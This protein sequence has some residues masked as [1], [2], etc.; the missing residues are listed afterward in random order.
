ML[1]KG[2]SMRLVIAGGNG[3]IGRHFVRHA[4]DA[5]HA[6]TLVVRS[7][8]EACPEGVDL[9][10]GGI[11]ALCERPDVLEAADAVCHLASASIPATSQRDPLAD[12]T[13]N[14]LPAIRL[15]EAMRAHGN[16][17]ILFLSSGGAIYG[18][19]Q[20]TPIRENHPT[21]PISPYGVGKLAIEKYLEC[22][23][24]LHGFSTVAIRPANPYGPDQGKVGELGVVWTFIR[25]IQQDAVA[26]LYGDGSTVR[27]H[28]HVDDLCRLMLAC[29][30]QRAEGT[31]N[32]G[33]G[34]GTSLKEL[35]TM[36]ERIVG[37]PL[38]IDR[39]PARAFD[40]PA[41]VL[42]ITRARKELGWEPQISLEQG[43]ARMT[44]AASA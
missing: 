8:P 29:L 41:I 16:R 17:R 24:A 1:T 11:D 42:D 20:T 33:G 38:Q 35:I 22:Y 19:P 34:Q 40:P 6:V 36:I 31:F 15:L 13:G 26:T 12:A 4:R 7:A 23:A 32:C 28:V 43:I 39:K 5:G 21:N 30:D 3:F 27:D 44:R 25:M 14:I 18:V 9:V 2:E 37:K 10:T